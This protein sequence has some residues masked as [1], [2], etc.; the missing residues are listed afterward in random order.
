MLENRLLR[1]QSWQKVTDRD[2]G[3]TEQM[4]I[5]KR[6]HES[7]KRIG[8]NFYVTQQNSSVMYCKLDRL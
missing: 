5:N 4:A 8:R 6:D 2:L 7:Q 3:G 1:D